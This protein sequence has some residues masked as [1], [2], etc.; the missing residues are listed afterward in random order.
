VSPRALLLANLSAVA[1][2]YVGHGFSTL[3]LA[4]V[5]E[6]AETGPG[7]RRRYGCR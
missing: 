3:V 5:L 1:A 6:T 2:N 7:T 4:G